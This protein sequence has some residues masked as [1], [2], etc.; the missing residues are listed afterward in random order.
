MSSS[1]LHYCTIWVLPALILFETATIVDGPGHHL[2]GW[3]HN[4]PLGSLWFCTCKVD[5]SAGI[6]KAIPA[7]S[8]QHLYILI[9]CLRGVL[10]VNPDTSVG[11]S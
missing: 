4:L 5:K 2:G 3:N 10:L 11:L 1:K 9:F 6:Q 8:S 7:T